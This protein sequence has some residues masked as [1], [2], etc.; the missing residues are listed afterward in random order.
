MTTWY[1]AKCLACGTVRERLAFLS[2]DV[3]RG[4]STPAYRCPRCGSRS[5]QKVPGAIER[6]RPR[7]HQLFHYPEGGNRGYLDGLL[8]RL[9]K[10]PLS[11]SG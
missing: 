10:V 11:R 4:A 6:I 9:D 2:Y 7:A 5:C 8:A 3:Q 1:K